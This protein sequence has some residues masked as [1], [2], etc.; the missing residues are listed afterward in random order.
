LKTP[1]EA[2]RV[3]PPIYFSWNHPPMA[4]AQLAARPHEPP[5]LAARPLEELVHEALVLNPNV[6]SRNLRFE[7][8]AG[9]VTLRGTVGTFYQKQ[10]AQ[11]ALRRVD[12][13][14]RIDNELEVN[15]V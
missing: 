3:P 12:G 8:A 13:V 9:L 15:W 2:H 10:L 5:P 6:Q 4:N 7:A 11:E 14:E 1:R